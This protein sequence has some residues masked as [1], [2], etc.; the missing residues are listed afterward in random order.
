MAA[1][2]VL[3]TGLAACEEQVNVR[4]NLPD[5]RTLSEVK[6]G[7][8][9]RG[10]VEAVLGT[11][12]T[13]A[14]FDNEVWYYIGGRVKTVS[15]FAPELLERKVIAISFDKKGV[16]RELRQL[17]ADDGK[18]I[19]IVA[20]ETPTKGR[21][22]TVLRQLIGNVGRFGNPKADSDSPGNLP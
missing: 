4:G 16:V 2:A 3:A 19:R 14:T 21:E 6:V 5:A 18:D 12:S 11:P 22:L 8:S 1:C 17:D 9:S 15:F 20:R 13:V 7:K 10:Q